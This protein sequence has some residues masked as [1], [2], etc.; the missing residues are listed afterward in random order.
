MA[1]KT[2]HLRVFSKAELVFDDDETRAIL[3]F[4]FPHQE[5]QVAQTSLTDELRGFAQALLVEAV[6]A[7]YA[8]GY[9]EALFQ[10]F[11]FRMPSV[12]MREA[13][14]KLGRNGLKNWFR[15]AKQKDLSNP[16]VF[17]IVRKQISSQFSNP[18]RIML[19]AK[20]KGGTL[21]GHLNYQTDPRGELWGMG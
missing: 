17:E 11:Y 1:G 9:V 5:Q 4:F 6:D 20:W 18:L 21:I 16:K 10:S 15:H 13:L 7:T 2:I 12:P 14:R 19:E 3:S 8:L